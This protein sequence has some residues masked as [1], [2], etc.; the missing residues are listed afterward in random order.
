[1]LSCHQFVASQ[2][3]RQ[4]FSL[5]YNLGGF[6]R[7]PRLPKAVRYWSLH[8]L[9]VKL[10]RMGGQIVSHARQIVFELAE[11]A[12]PRDLFEPPWRG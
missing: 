12:V 10:M 6:L 2:V 4:P 11:V 1:M 8:S 9:Q 5:A 7:R 3:R